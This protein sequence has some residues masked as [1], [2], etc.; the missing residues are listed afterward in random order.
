MLVFPRLFM[1][2]G[3]VPHLRSE[4]TMIYGFVDMTSDERE[5]A[6]SASSSKRNRICRNR[7]P[8]GQLTSYDVT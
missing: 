6:V 4:Q 3:L 1:I 2:A 5:F 7:I 8:A